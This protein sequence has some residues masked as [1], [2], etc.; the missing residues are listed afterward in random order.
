MK[1]Y[2]FID[3]GNSL[4]ITAQCNNK[5]KSHVNHDELIKN[6]ANSQNVNNLFNFMWIRFF[7]VNIPQLS[8]AL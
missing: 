4:W 7:T 2:D 6:K 1:K 3:T 8:P 5:I